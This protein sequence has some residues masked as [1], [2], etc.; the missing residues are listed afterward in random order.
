M[1]Q[2][3]DFT[4]D[5][6]KS[7]REKIFYEWLCHTLNLHL[8]WRLQLHLHK[9]LEEKQ[10]S[11]FTGFQNINIVFSIYHHCCV[12]WTFGTQTQLES[13]IV[14]NTWKLKGK[15]KK[16][17]LIILYSPNRKMS[18][19]TWMF[20]DILLIDFLNLSSDIQIPSVPWNQ[21]SKAM[22][23]NNTKSSYRN[24]QFQRRV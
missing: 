23:F 3:E 15:T 18:S 11:I 4:S 24:R 19:F 6:K 17:Q 5:K 13:T 1:Y 2:E 16:P 20:Y 14:T 10:L 7:N 22:V 8:Y 12:S 9:I 21:S